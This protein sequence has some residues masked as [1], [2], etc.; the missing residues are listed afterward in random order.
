MGNSKSS[1][2]NQF[3]PP[4][5]KYTALI[6]EKDVEELNKKID[7]LIAKQADPN[8]TVFEGV[9]SLCFIMLDFK[10]SSPSIKR[11][12]FD[13][14]K[15]LLDRGADPNST[16]KG[17]IFLEM[18]FPIKGVSAQNLE[19]ELEVAHMLFKK[20]ADVAKSKDMKNLLAEI[21]HTVARMPIK[22]AKSLLTELIRSSSIHMVRILLSKP[23]FETLKQF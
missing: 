17:K 12:R 6:N 1:D 13:A 4:W 10:K 14:I 18:I 3:N 5:E 7:P 20:G 22:S 21:S 11:I 19:F 15:I 23:F 9:S 8:A 2:Q 16:H